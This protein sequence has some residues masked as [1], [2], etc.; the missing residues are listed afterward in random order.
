MS[1]NKLSLTIPKP[2][3]EKWDTMEVAE[4]GK[5]CA[6]CQKTVIDF[7]SAS[8]AIILS[9]LETNKSICGRLTNNQLNRAL[10]KRIEPNSTRIWIAASLLSIIGLG[11]PTANAQLQSAPSEQ[12][13]NV[14]AASQDQTNNTFDN[15]TITG[16][17]QDDMG[18]PFPG[19]NVKVKGTKTSTT[20]DANGKFTIQAKRT[21]KLMISYI[22]YEEQ[23]VEIKNVLD[24]QIILKPGD[25][26]LLGEVVVVAKP[27]F[28]KRLFRKR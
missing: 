9:A 6:S 27:S 7:S 19:A 15:T 26:M 17:I 20:T 14:K 5:F 28:F 1:A 13:P 16:T 24:L 8:D 22:G 3:L 18:H 10:I 4:Q 23:T 11:A 25:Q 12:L 21:D 2:C